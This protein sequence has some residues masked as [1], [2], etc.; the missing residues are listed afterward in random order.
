MTEKRWAKIVFE[1]ENNNIYV[2]YFSLA[3]SFVNVK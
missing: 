3:L 1:I 2:S